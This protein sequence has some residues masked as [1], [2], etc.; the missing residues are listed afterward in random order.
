VKQKI[1]YLELLYILNY[2]Y[3]VSLVLLLPFIAKELHINI[4]QVGILS[5]ILNLA[6]IL[7]SI[8][9]AHLASKFGGFKLLVLSLLIYGVSYLS[10]SYENSFLLLLLSF[11]VAGIALSTCQPLSFALL[12][13]WVEKKEKGKVLGKFT[14]VSDF[15]RFGFSIITPF[16]IGI[17]GRLT[18]TRVLSIIPLAFFLY[19]YF[20]HLPKEKQLHEQKPARNT[21][22]QK[23]LKNYNL[24]LA[25]LASAFDALASSSVFVFLPFLF[26]AR[27]INLSLI[28]TLAGIFFV[29]TFFGKRYIGKLSDKYGDIKLFVITELLM[30][31]CLI[32]L[33]MFQNIIFTI[34]FT[35][36]LGIMTKGTAPSSLSMVSNTL[37]ENTSHEKAF[38]FT[39]VLINSANTLAP[40]ILGFISL[41]FGIEKAFIACALFAIL[42]I[43][44]SLALHGR[45]RSLDLMKPA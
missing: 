24:V 43:I 9:I 17:W 32:L 31:A 34:L 40:I 39:S 38:G 4:A 22:Y 5:G 1:F 23:L 30:A 35:I 37:D 29:G 16:L 6:G 3:H 41:H 45:Y 10:T 14:S 19:L 33:V 27:H 13:Q 8:P 18:T 26:I 28:G 42:A 44:P 25:G 12:S 7:F 15:G 36:L 2:G 11:L 21:S 20:Y